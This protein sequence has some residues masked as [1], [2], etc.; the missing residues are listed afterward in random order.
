MYKTGYCF[1]AKELFDTFNLKMLKIKR[2]VVQKKYGVHSK[3]DFCASVLLYCFYLILLDII[4]NNITFVLPTRNRESVIQVKP[5][6]EDEFK[7]AYQN[8][9]FKG[10]DFLNSNFTGYQLMFRYKYDGGFRE[11]SIYIN[12]NIK[13]RFYELINQGKVYY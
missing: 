11:K 3:Q 6:F 10:I 13:S 9:K 5:F 1:T 7:E 12:N 4:E 2:D 8:G